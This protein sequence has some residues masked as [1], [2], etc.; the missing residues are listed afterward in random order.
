M[1][2]HPESPATELEEILTEPSGMF[3]AF[4]D[5]ESIVGLLVASPV[6][7]EI[8]SRQLAY[9]TLVPDRDYA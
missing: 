4:H 1:R 3:A 9:P 2:N 7:R 8:A 6:D 5:D